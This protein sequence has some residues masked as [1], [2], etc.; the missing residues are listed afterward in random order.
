M[1]LRSRL[2]RSV[3]LLTMVATFAIIESVTPG[4]FRSTSRARCRR[5]AASSPASALRQW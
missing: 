5:R 2:F 4:A 3:F 1:K